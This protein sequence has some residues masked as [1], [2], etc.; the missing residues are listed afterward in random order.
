MDRAS[1][2]VTSLNTQRL[3][4][5]SRFH[6]QALQLRCQS[7]SELVTALSDGTLL[8]YH[9]TLLPGEIEGRLVDAG[10]RG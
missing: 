6:R 9:A 8:G 3:M 5:R 1:G 4:H 2:K 10:A 7:H